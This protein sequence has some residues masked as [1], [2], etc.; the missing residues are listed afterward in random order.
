MKKVLFF[1]L[2][3][4]LY[5]S[6]TAQ[7]CCD[8]PNCKAAT[9]ASAGKVIALLKSWGKTGSDST[10]NAKLDTFRRNN[11]IK[12]KELIDIVTQYKNWTND[13]T[14]IP[15]S[16]GACFLDAFHEEDEFA[17][18]WFTFIVRKNTQ[19]ATRSVEFCKGWDLHLDIGQGGS[20]WFRSSESYLFSGRL[21]LSYTFARQD[22]GG[23]IRLLIGP[24]F[25]YWHQNALLMANPRIE[26][27][28]K[29][30]ATPYGSIANLKLIGQ[31]N[32]NDK[33][34]IGGAGIALEVARQ[35]G[36]HLMAEYGSKNSY[37]I[38][39][40]IFYRIKL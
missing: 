35:F 5:T 22:C 15:K 30:I 19:S 39:T 21:L 37:L 32:V 9:S 18:D 6:I 16:K 36:L 1:L 17:L 12:Y 10:N 33:Y 27:R 7:N 31:A 20:D 40:G 28:L 26:Y 23:R 24:S 38:Q 3:T 14:T 2:F 8:D 11:P 34:F 29:D 25:Y 13:T 4:S